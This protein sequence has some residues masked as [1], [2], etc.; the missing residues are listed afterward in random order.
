MTVRSVTNSVYTPPVSTVPTTAKSSKKE[1][2]RSSPPSVS[3]QSSRY[4][5]PLRSAPAT[6]ATFTRFGSTTA[7]P[8]CQK[9][10]SPMERGVVPG[11][12]GT[13]WHS[14]CLICGGREARGRHGRRRD[15]QPGCGKQLDS[16]AKQGA[17]ERGVWCRECLVSE[18]FLFLHWS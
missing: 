3:S 7:C 18:T 12:Q 13:R 11:P 10:V 4:S 6:K 14:S 9:S 17:D 1:V 2:R 5:A 8:E 16:S 15:G